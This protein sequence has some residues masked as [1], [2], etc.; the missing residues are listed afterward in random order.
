MTLAYDG[1]AK[2]AEECSEVA[3]D[4]AKLIAFPPAKGPHPDGVTDLDHLTR[5]CGDALAA[6]QL[7]VETHD[8][9]EEAMMD[10]ARK[11]YNLFKAWHADPE[12]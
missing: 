6:I 4:C 1:L 10:H 7:V 12:A 2:L 11:K 8:L 3:Q 9:D 5:E